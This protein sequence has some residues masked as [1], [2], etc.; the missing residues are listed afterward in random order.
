[1]GE[2]KKTSKMGTFEGHLEVDTL[3]KL[4]IYK[5]LQ[6]L[7]LS[8]LMKENQKPKKS[9]LKITELFCLQVV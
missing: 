2:N 6:R 4:T 1:M 9:V 5:G 3:N 7:S 8:E